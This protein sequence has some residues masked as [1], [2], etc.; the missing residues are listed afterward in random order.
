DEPHVAAH[1][2]PVRANRLHFAR[3]GESEQHGLHAQAHLA[4]FVEEQRAAVG[5]LNEAALVSKGARKAALAV[6]EKFGFEERLRNSTAIEGHES[7][8]TPGVLLV[9]QSRDD[10][11]ADS[12][13]S[14]NQHLCI[15]A[16]GIAD[17]RA[18]LLDRGTVTDERGVLLWNNL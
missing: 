14:E 6:A 7:M 17:V 4:K 5:L 11:L 16:R 12:G 8:T 15:R 1:Y 2:R 10:F 13:F 9:N 18:Q 3:F